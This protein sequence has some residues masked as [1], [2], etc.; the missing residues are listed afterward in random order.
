MLLDSKD[1]ARIY[2]ELAA[3]YKTNGQDYDKA[4]L[5]EHL[6]E[7]LEKLDEE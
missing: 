3:D 7:R 1:L 5:L 4:A 2:R 6:A